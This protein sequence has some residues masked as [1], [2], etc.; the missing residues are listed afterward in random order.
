MKIK[1]LDEMEETTSVNRYLFIRYNIMQTAKADLSMLK[2]EDLFS[3][4]FV[5]LRAAFGDFSS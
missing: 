3:D 1:L 4:E 2:T 5:I